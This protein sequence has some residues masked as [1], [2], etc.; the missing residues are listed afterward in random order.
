VKK[1]FSMSESTF[2]K[3]RKILEQN[4]EVEKD[5]EG[6]CYWTG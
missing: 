1:K 6:K 5:E 2:K 3:Y 4:G